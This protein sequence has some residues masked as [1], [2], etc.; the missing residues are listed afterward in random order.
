MAKEKGWKPLPTSLKILFV[1]TL[2]SIPFSLI[3]LLSIAKTGYL[4]LGFQVFGTG[5]IILYILS[6]A[7]TIIFP[8]GLWNRY[9]WT[10][11]YGLAYYGFSLLNTLSGMI[12]TQ[13]QIEQQLSQLPAALP[14]LKE[15]MYAS[16]IITAIISIAVTIIFLTIIYKKRDYFK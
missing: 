13:K 11:K 2:I 12:P 5:A 9:H 15:A 1:L 4:L 16:I 3:G 7:A 6:L 10:A 14:G 8:I